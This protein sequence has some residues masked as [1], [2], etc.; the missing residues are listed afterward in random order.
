MLRALQRSNWLQVDAA[1]LLGMSKYRLS[2][3]LARHQLR[4]EVKRRREAWTE[5]N[6]N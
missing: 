1:R 3:S 2:R 6:G 5:A 4:E